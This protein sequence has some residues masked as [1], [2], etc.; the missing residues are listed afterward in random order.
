MP[1]DASRPGMASRATLAVLAGL[2]LGTLA[3]RPQLVG[4]GPLLPD[5]QADLGVSYGMVGLLAAIP[6][7]LMGLFAPFGPWVAGRIGPRDAVALCMVAIIGFGLLRSGLPG[8]AAILLT[9][10][11]IGIGMGTAGAVLPIVV[12]QRAPDEPARATGFYAAG[13]VAGSLIAA[14]AAV[15]LAD[16]LGGWRA[17][18]LVFAVAGLG[19]LAA[20]LLFLRPDPPAHRATGRPARLPWTS[21]TAWLL[22][23]VFATQSVLY[24]SAIS[25]LPSVYVE[26]GWSEADAA[27]LNAM[28]HA[29][30]LAAGIALPLVA[31]RVGTRRSQLIAVASVTLSGFLGFVLV[32]GPAFVW[33]A[34]IGAGMGAVFPLVLTL[35]VD[36]AD[37]PA[38]VGATAAFMLLF[39]YMI[40]STGPIVLGILRDSTG[41]YQTSLWLLVVLSVTLLLVSLALTPARLRRGVRP[42][43][44]EALAVP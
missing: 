11:G 9:T 18:L 36:V 31:D 32:P 20:W 33:A 17:A 13:I 14:A 44:R 5:I 16:A 23:A 30:G 2:F 26:R 42:P 15:P 10:V 12:R 7:L 19:S 28:I 40:S 25:W 41:N 3:M 43:E 6:I 34:L 37:G 39:G 38:A 21:R 27:N 24:Y 22:V 35:P 1:D 29:V 4:I 8:I